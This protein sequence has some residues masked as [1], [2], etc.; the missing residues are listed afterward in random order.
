MS[1]PSRQTD[2]TRRE[3]CLHLSLRCRYELSLSL[4]GRAHALECPQ[5]NL[6]K[7]ILFQLIRNYY[8]V[9]SGGHILKVP[10]THLQTCG[11]P[12]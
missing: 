9:K 5:L 8:K 4:K 10:G 7:T 2:D 6:D 1:R 3:T 11:R 12:H